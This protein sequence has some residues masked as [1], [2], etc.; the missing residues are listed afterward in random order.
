MDRNFNKKNE[1]VNVRYNLNLAK[2]E[3][4]IKWTDAVSEGVDTQWEAQ[5]DSYFATMQGNP[6]FTREGKSK[7]KTVFVDYFIR[8]LWADVNAGV[9]KNDAKYTALVL[10][11]AGA[12]N[13]LAWATRAACVWQAT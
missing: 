10:N 12:G 5:F 1:F 11:S 8:K 2:T 6:T 3:I 13:S 7:G 9:P 4:D